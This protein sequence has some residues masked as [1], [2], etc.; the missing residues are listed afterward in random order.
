[1]KKHVLAFVAASMLIVGC[2]NDPK[3]KEEEKSTSTE[4]KTESDDKQKKD[5]SVLSGEFIYTAD[6]AVLKGNDFIYG[7]VL[8]SMATQLSEQVEKLKR[9]DFDM[10]PV[11][12]QAKIKPNPME[13]GWDEVVE[14]KR[15]IKVLEPS[16]EKTI[17]VK[18]EQAK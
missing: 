16:D 7:V 14:I 18:G 15:I 5:L 12:I 10:V 6:A 9:D 11:I 4:Q 17:R 3:Q 8:D 2:K 13:E 1:M